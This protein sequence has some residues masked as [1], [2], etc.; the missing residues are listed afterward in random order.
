MKKII[1]RTLLGAVV[2]I[3]LLTAIILVRTATFGITTPS[4]KP[5]EAI[6]VDPKAADRL[7]EGVRFETVSKAKHHETDFEQFD[8]YLKFLA[9]AYP[10][11]HKTLKVEV[12]S[13]ASLIM[14]WPGTDKSLEPILLLGHMDVVPAEKE[15]LSKW[16]HGPFSGMVDKTHVWGRGT[17]DDKVNVQGLLEAAEYL[18]NKGFQ[19]K[20][21]IVFAF[22]QDEEVGGKHGA[23]KIAEHFEKQNLRFEFALDEGHVITKGIV[24]G[25]KAPSAL[26]GLAEKGFVSLELTVNS[27]GGHSSMPP[28]HTALGLLARALTQLEQHQMPATLTGPSRKMFQQLGPHMAFGNKMVMANLWLFEPILIGILEGKPTTNATV[29][30]TTAVTQAQGSPQDNVLPKRAR[31]VV[32]FRI[33]PGDTKESVIAHVKRVINDERVKVSVY[34]GFNTDPSSI[35]STDARGYKLIEQTIRQTWPTFHVA[36][37]LTIGAT[38]ARHYSKVAKNTYRFLPIILGPK[39][40]V[41]LH[42]INERIAIQNYLDA[43]RF[44]ILLLKNSAG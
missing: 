26:I 15:T 13:E 23:A 40:T 24:P 32:N 9:I 11:T 22:G 29:R 30:T 16:T 3:V 14:T 4:S 36:P 5:A 42:G 20:R 8:S 38:D 7:A 43:V 27:T 44:Y 33:L 25:V 31:A 39:D 34:P 21:T 1:I 2:I 19:P 17:L 18:I 37:S 12:I 35:S 28:K 10:H 6:K 41:R